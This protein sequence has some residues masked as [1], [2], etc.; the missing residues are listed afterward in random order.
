MA[1]EKS[2][3]DREIE[4]LTYNHKSLHD[5]IWGNHRVS[6]L[7]TSIFIPVLFAMLGYLVREYDSLS[8]FQVVM[9]FLVTE[10]LAFIWLLIMRIFDHYNE[11]R[12]GKLQEIEVKLGEL[13]PE[14]KFK[15][16]TLEGYK[17]VPEELK[18]SPHRIYHILFWLYTA[19]N[20]GFLLTKLVEV[21]W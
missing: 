18:V 2:A 9:A 4:L 12:R 5:S 14:A 11:V 6:W 1:G 17:Q 3:V 7:V 10:G 13:V 20:L 21:P 16:Y 15:L 8:T 19:L